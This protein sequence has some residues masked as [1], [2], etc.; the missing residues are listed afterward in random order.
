M[1]SQRFFL[2][3]KAYEKISPF[4]FWRDSTSYVEAVQWL[5]N[6]IV[7]KLSCAWDPV[8]KTQGLTWSSLPG[9]MCA[10]VE[11]TECSARLCCS[12]RCEDP[13]FRFK[14]RDDYFYWQNSSTENVF[15]L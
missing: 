10:E 1:Y 13:G 15:D 12:I 14:I 5:L 9:S 3:K 8:R 11:L 7:M 6:V 4:C 2:T